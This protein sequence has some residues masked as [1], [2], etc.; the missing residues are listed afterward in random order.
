M[1]DNF[2]I[3][4]GLF[5]REFENRCKDI[6]EF[7]CYDSPNWEKVISNGKEMI[8]AKYLASEWGREIER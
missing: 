8:K 7:S 6:A 4:Q 1:T 5:L 2:K 3:E